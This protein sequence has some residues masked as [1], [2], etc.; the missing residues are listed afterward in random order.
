MSRG[1]AYTR[2][3]RNK[4]IARKKRICKRFYG[5]DWYKHDGQYSKGKI[6]CSCR[7]CTYSKYYDL[8][9]HKDITEDIR[10]KQAVDDYYK[11]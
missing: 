5:F 2:E 8:P 6:H 1:I 11:D 9:T 10:F 7:M 3:V 4:A